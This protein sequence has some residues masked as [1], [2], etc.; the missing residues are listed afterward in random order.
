METLHVID[1]QQLANVCQSF[2]TFEQ[3]QML[4][5]HKYLK[6]VEQPIIIKKLNLINKLNK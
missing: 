6:D 3:Q 5:H 2:C 1:V 4:D